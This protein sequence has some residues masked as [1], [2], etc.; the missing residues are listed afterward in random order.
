M[1]QLI[2][3]TMIL[4]VGLLSACGAEP[5]AKVPTMRLT[6]A[7]A[8]RAIDLHVGGKLK[9]ALPSNPTTGFQWEVGAGDPAILRPSG[10]PEFESSGGGVGSGGRTTLRFEAVAPGQTRLK[11]IYHRPFEKDTPPV[12]TFD[13]VVTVR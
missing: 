4:I 7:D 13:V 6:E 1:V 3:I 12:Q 2:M 8:D 10:Q 9:I 11:L 5:A